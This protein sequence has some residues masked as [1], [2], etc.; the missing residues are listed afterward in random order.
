MSPQAEVCVKHWRTRGWG[1]HHRDDNVR[2]EAI[3]TA[4]QTWEAEVTEQ[5][6]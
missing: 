1:G 3:G 4:W 5:G 6:R 2:G